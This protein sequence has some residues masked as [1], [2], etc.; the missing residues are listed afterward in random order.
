[1][2][3]GQT[4][5]LTRSTLGRAYRAQLARDAVPAAQ[6]AA[7][8]VASDLLAVGY[9]RRLLPVPV[10][11]SAAER[12]ALATDLAT[13]H[14]LLTSLPER[15]F[16]ADAGALARGVGMNPV[17]QETVRRGSAGPRLVRLARSDL[18]R[19]REGFKLLELNITSALGGF[20]NAEI[21]RAMLRHPSLARFVERHGL[22][23][24][25][26]LETIVSALRAECAEH[27]GADRPTVA[28]A[29]WPESYRTYEPRLRV[30]AALLDGMG[31]DAV[32]CHVGHLSERNGRLEVHGRPVDAVFRFFLVEEIVAPRDAELLEP[33]LRAVEAGTVGMFSRLDAELYGNKGALALLS[34]ERNR[35]LFDA[36]E[37]ACIDRFL[38]WTR[39]VRP[40]VCEPDGSVCDLESFAKAR[41]HDLILKPTLLHGGCGIVAGWTVPPGEWLARVAEA[42]DGPYVLQRRIRPLAETFPG[43]EVGTERTMYLNWGVFVGDPQVTGSDGYGGCIVRASADP[44][45]GVISMSSGAQVGCVFNE[46][47]P[48]AAAA[49]PDLGSPAERESQP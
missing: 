29:D 16:G 15:L 28:L 41:Q 2:D 19:E 25:D 26:T 4:I 38:P 44:Q 23:Y 30:L 13:I 36:A 40:T 9:H 10:F 20:E 27:L 48:S 17:Q 12:T 3:T 14:R 35:D 1:M 45:V 11:L 34:D 49:S 24:V 37:R 32:P 39:H 46:P 47:R 5:T 22:E 8:A 6:L 42:V 43:D 31:I 18:Y 21:N 7:E 33:V